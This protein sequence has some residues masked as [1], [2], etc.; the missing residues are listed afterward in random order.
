MDCRWAMCVSI[1]GRGAFEMWDSGYVVLFTVAAHT[2]LPPVCFLLPL[3]LLSV[4]FVFFDV[5][6]I[7]PG[8]ISIGKVP[9]TPIVFICTS[10]AIYHC[11]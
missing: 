6:L 9:Y 1:L 4:I 3:L 11:H 10:T 5:V 2:S 8:G 7:Y